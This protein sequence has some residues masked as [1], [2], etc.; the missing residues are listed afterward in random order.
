V[1][2]DHWGFDEG[3]AHTARAPLALLTDVW[4]RGAV[5]GAEAVP[6]EG[7]AL[8]VVD[9]PSDPAVAHVVLAGALARA[10]RRH[11]RCLLPG[12]A[13]DRPWLSEAAR[14]FGFV[15]AHREDALGLLGEGHLV[16]V[17]V[18]GPHDT[19]F[20]E[21]ALAAR[22][23]VVPCAIVDRPYLPAPGPLRLAPLPT[24]RRVAFVAPLGPYAADPEDRAAVLDHADLVRERLAE[25]VQLSV[26]QLPE[27][28][29]PTTTTGET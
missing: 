14:R 16:G 20:A 18:S 8:V 21:I 3:F 11:P 13:F 29:R 17:S 25:A 15:P 2:A 26:T 6:D 23:P 19:L 1:S 7:P 27:G 5:T 24:R 28:R 10:G 12:S 9:C 4:W 22:V